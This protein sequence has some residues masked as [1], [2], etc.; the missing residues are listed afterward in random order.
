MHSPVLAAGIDGQPL[1][2]YTWNHPTSLWPFGSLGEILEIDQF[3][4]IFS[5]SFSFLQ[6]CPGGSRAQPPYDRYRSQRSHEYRRRVEGYFPPLCLSLWATVSQPSHD[7]EW[8]PSHRLRSAL[9]TIPSFSAP[10]GYP[11][12]RRVDRV[13][14]KVQLGRVIGRGWDGRVC[15]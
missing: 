8:C 10:T 2:I 3:L 7:G 14:V 6:E 5:F 4:S 1:V 9:T 15:D 11:P 12:P 13:H